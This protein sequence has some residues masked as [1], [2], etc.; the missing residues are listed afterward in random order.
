MLKPSWRGFVSRVGVGLAAGVT[1]DYV[2]AVKLGRE[3][4][5]SVINGSK[6]DVGGLNRA[7]R[8]RHPE[9]A[10]GRLVSCTGIK[11]IPWGWG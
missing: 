3:T 6:E 1:G 7:N 11:A 2:G 4:G 9:S 5:M 8:L 10:L